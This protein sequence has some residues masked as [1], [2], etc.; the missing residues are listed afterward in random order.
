[1]L[2]LFLVLNEVDY[3]DDILAK[4]VEVGVKGATILE[5]QGMASAM[6]ESANRGVAMFASLGHLLDNAHPYN[7]TIFTVLDNEKILEKTVAGVAEV[8]KDHNKPGAGFM[9][10]VPIGSVYSLSKLG[11]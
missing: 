9:F 2:A 3:L 8:L 1:M 10:T 11:K 6:L 4:F 5:S 7:K